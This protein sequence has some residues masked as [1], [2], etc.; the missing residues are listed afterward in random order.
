M[1][2]RI[3]NC[4]LALVLCLVMCIGTS[5][6]AFAASIPYKNCYTEGRGT[7][8]FYI[9][10]KNFSGFENTKIWHFTVQTQGYPSN[11]NITVTIY[12]GNNAVGFAWLS[13]NQKLERI[14]FDENV[15][16]PA[17]QYSIKI[18][19]ENKTSNGWTGIWLYH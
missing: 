19:V 15:Y 6:Q 11:A 17:G 8:T 10:T 12:Y 5:V 1:K 14:G 2:K 16:F 3:C 13:G 7:H 18:S 9:N 4:L